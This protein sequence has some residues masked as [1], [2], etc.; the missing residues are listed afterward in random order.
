[1]KKII[2]FVTLRYQLHQKGASLEQD[3]HEVKHFHETNDYQRSFNEAFRS[4]SEQFFAAYM[5]T[6]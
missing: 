4:P 5:F 6:A 2:A 1:M 3:I